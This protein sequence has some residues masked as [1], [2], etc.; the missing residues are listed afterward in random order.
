MGVCV[1][2]SISHTMRYA[3]I[4]FRKIHYFSCNTLYMYIHIFCEL[5]NLYLGH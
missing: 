5:Y 3:V 4:K 2:K 1:S